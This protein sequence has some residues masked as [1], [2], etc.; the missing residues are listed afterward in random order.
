MLLWLSEKIQICKVDNPLSLRI[1]ASAKGK[2][3]G[4]QQARWWFQNYICI[5]TPAWVR[6]P[7]GR[8]SSKFAYEKKFIILGGHY[9]MHP[10]RFRHTQVMEQWWEMQHTPAQKPAKIFAKKR[11]NVKH[12]R[13]ARKLQK[14]QELWR[15]SRAKHINSAGKEQTKIPK[16]MK[17]KQKMINKTLNKK[18]HVENKIR[19]PSLTGSLVLSPGNPPKLAR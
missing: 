9:C 7:F 3:F 15:G 2:R 10:G 11:K 13:K 17:G 5:F 18:T 14:R 4:D 19:A 1:I 16:A 6:F 8:K 12:A